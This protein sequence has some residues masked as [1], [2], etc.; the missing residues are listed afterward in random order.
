MSSQ[1][2]WVFV[3]VRQALITS[4]IIIS[5]V[6]IFL[7]ILIT[8]QYK[9]TMRHIRLKRKNQNEDA[10]ENQEPRTNILHFLFLRFPFDLHFGWITVGTV[11]NVN[12]ALAPLGAEPAAEIACAFLSLVFLQLVAS[13]S[14]FLKRANLVVALVIAIAA[15]SF[16]QN[17]SFQNEYLIDRFGEHVV[18]AA[19]YTAAGVLILTQ[20]SIVIRAFVFP[21]LKFF[22]GGDKQYDTTND[23]QATKSS[24][25]RF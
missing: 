19:E 1:T 25:Q 23:E 10:G 8:N 12:L 17:L 6:W 3:F 4:I 21:V 18:K 14:L 5:A 15:A 7:L 16:A 11:L 20:F 13:I 24:Y 2:I 22:I 9:I